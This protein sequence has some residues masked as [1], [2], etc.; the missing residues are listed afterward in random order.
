M[1]EASLIRQTASAGV[2]IGDILLLGRFG[3]A[4]CNHYRVVE[5][6]DG[7]VVLAPVVAV[8]IKNDDGTF[9]TVWEVARG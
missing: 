6:V 4:Y 7:D 2:E 5:K 8:S 9:S 1:N 3:G